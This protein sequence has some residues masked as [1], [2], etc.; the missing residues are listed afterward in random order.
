[1]ATLESIGISAKPLAADGL[2]RLYLDDVHAYVSRRVPN[3]E[4]AE[5]ATAE[6]FAAAF[7]HLKRLRGNDPRVWLIGIARK[8]VADV[9]R[10]RGGFI[11][12]SLDQLHDVEAL[13]ASQPEDLLEIRNLILALPEDQREAL[14]LQHIE[15]FSQ[16]DIAKIMRKSKAAVNG[17]QQRGRA[18]VLR[19]GK[20]FFLPEDK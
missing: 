16:R 2:Q 14:M 3:R 19:S 4:D 5:D 11:E 13:D 6:T 17:L 10:K 15:G 12:V 1:M 7:A 20:S 18:S 8:K 9:Y